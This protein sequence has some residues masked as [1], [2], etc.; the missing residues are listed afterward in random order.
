[1]WRLTS[2]TFYAN[3]ILF[4]VSFYDSP[5]IKISDEERIGLR[6]LAILNLGLREKT[7]G[8]INASRD[9]ASDS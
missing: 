5:K 4:G 1:M 8:K 9:S 7:Q 6:A 3:M 2:F